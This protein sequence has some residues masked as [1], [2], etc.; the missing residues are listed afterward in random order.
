MSEGTLEPTYAEEESV[1]PVF[2]DDQGHDSA[3]RPRRLDEYV[4][5]SAI[6][7]SIALTIEAARRRGE[8]A[9]HMLFAGPPGLGKTTL[10][11]IVAAELQVPLRITSG[12]ALERGG[13]LASIVASLQ[14]GEVLFIDE[15]HRLNRTVE[16]MLYPAMEDFALDLILGKGPAAR[17]MRIDLP[18]FT[19]IGATTQPGSLTSP[20]RDRF[21]LH[22]HLEY[23]TDDELAQIVQRSARLLDVSITDDAA[24]LL[25]ARSRRTP[26]VANRLIK[27]VRDYATVHG[28]GMV[29][30]E[31]VETTLADLGIDE[32]GLDSVDRRILQTVI[33]Q[34]NGGPAGVE[35]I[36]AATAL[37]RATL[38][39][40]YEPY[41]LQMG[42][43][44][45]TPRGRKVTPATFQHLGIT[46]MV[47][48]DFDV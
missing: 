12:P 6:K 34:F 46:P 9:E 29:R 20:L 16:E 27:R 21:G 14:P 3:L 17:T 42:F 18:R 22:Y 41:L 39:D 24:Q 2:T 1:T 10:A 7:K 35:A 13:D 48:L 8:P 40:M 30:R 45:R 26:R 15:I 5:Q 11:G 28:D 37:E 38:E 25:S 23:Y 4:G 31:D 36:A 47:P 32:K 44:V 43:L 33:E 19:L